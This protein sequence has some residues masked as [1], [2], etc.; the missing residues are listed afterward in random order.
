MAEIVSIPPPRHT[1]VLLTTGMHPTTEATKEGGCVREFYA[2][3]FVVIVSGHLVFLKIFKSAFVVR[4]YGLIDARIILTTVT[5]AI[6][7]AIAAL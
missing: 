3:S 2:D 1:C 4:Y 7:I 5:T 6:R